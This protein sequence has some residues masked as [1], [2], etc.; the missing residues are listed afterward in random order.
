MII[1]SEAVGGERVYLNADINP[2]TIFFYFKKNII[3]Y[4]FQCFLSLSFFWL[5]NISYAGSFD[6]YHN[7]FIDA[8]IPDLIEIKGFPKRVDLE[9]HNGQL[10]HSPVNFEVNRSYA[11]R[12]KPLPYHIQ[13]TSSEGQSGNKFYLS[14][15]HTESEKLFLNVQF[16]DSEQKNSL[17]ESFSA[18]QPLKG[19]TTTSVSGKNSRHKRSA[20][21]LFYNNDRTYLG[22]KNSGHYSATF[23]IVFT[24]I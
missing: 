19:I 4:C 14:H 9:W 10:L 22:Q 15:V 18:G 6:A 12:D 23:T 3:I 5:S 8:Y 20:S 21:L 13:I 7:L 16:K 17:Y 2:R 24:A 11:S 1:A